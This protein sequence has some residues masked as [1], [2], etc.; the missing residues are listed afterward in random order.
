MRR[1]IS[2]AMAWE[3]CLHL[4]RRSYLLLLLLSPQLFFSE[5]SI[6]M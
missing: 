6:G 2:E 1:K 4:E 5:I 3:Y